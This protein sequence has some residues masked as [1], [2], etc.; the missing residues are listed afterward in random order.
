MGSRDAAVSRALAGFDD[1]GF[2]RLLTDLVA[3]KSTS[4]DPGH[5]ADLQAYLQ[6]AI[7]PWLERLGFTPIRAP[8]SGRS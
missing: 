3:Y 1:G 8:G 4:Q 6:D 7:R 2:K 5:E